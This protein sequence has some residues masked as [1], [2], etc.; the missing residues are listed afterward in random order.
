MATSARASTIVAFLTAVVC[1]P[2]PARA[3]EH[4]R[5]LHTFVDPLGGVGPGPLVGHQTGV[6][7]RTWALYGTAFGGQAAADC[8]GGCGIIFKLTPPPPGGSHW[9]KSRLRVFK[10]GPDGSLPYEIAFSASGEMYGTTRGGTGCGSIF[11]LTPPPQG[12]YFWNKVII[13]GPLYPESLTLDPSGSIYGVTYG[14]VFKLTRPRSGPEACAWTTTIL[15]E[16]DGSEGLIL[17]GHVVLGAAGKLYGVAE[18]SGPQTGGTV[19]ELS[20][21]AQTSGAWTSRVIY[22]FSGGAYPQSLIRDPSGALYG[23]TRGGAP[24]G[25]G[26][27]FRLQPPAPGQTAWTKTDLATFDFAHGDYP[28]EIV[29]LDDSGSLY[30][31]TYGRGFGY[32]Q[33]R[34]GV[35]FRLDPPTQGD[36]GWTKTVLAVTSDSIANAIRGA[37]VLDPAG[38]L[39]TSA[40]I[41]AQHFSDTVHNGTIFKVVP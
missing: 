15:H 9:T 31:A 14:T 2:T 36:G 17:K 4:V 25:A 21:P 35:V 6:D 26:T 27:V 1:M 5:F 38:D 24:S 28:T 20:P 39:Y 29:R 19:Y 37:L 30:G 18:V 32:D 10:G 3:D 13:G 11:R 34:G 40:Q 23:S 41:G 8:P 33:K 12:Q 16:F 22:A 7:P